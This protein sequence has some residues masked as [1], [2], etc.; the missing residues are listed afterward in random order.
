MGEKENPR[1]LKNYSHKKR[2]KYLHINSGS[3]LNDLPILSSIKINKIP[4]TLY[5]HN[6]A[7]QKVADMFKRLSTITITKTIAEWVDLN[8]C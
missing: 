3:Y 7:D 6:H 4:N 2:S 8:K 1:I 5:G